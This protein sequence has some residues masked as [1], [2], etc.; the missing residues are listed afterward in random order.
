LSVPPAIH[1]LI[2]TCSGINIGLRHILPVY[3]F[4][5]VLAAGAAWVFIR[6]DRRW[7]WVVGLLLVFQAVSTTRTFP[8]YIAYANE[9][10]GGPSN[11]Y[12]YL[13]DSNTDWAQQLKAAK[14]Y[15]AGRGVTSCWFAYF[16]EGVVDATGYYGIPCRPL[17]TTD[18]MWMNEEMDIPPVI[19]GPVLISAGTLS[20]YEFGSDD[21]NPYRQFMWLKP[22][23]AIQNG[24]LVFDGRFHVARASSL[25]HVQKARNRMGDGHLDQALAEAQA[26]VDVEPGFFEAQQVLGDTLMRLH[27]R[28]EARA[29]WQ[30]AL[31]L[32]KKLEPGIREDRI[33]AVERRLAGA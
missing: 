20:G 14:K 23:A 5:N 15:L 28:D 13:T 30:I 19:D 32:A 2:A 4:L 9:L 6:R 3:V 11:T 1:F 27:R 22:T 26:A 10:W 16:A 31:E 7:A 29:A 17:I 25:S 33:H 21:L 12:K 8:A 18:S 24:I